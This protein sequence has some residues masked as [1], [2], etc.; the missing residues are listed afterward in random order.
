[1]SLAW[2]VP[3]APRFRT[4]D[5]RQATLKDAVARRPDLVV[6][7]PIGESEAGR[8]LYGAVVG[9]GPLVV[10]LIAGCHADE[11][12]GPETLTALVEG[13]TR[14]PT[15]AALLARVRFVVVP[16]VNPD[17]E[18]AN[19]R[20]IERWPDPAAYLRDNV[21]ESPGRDV[22]FGFPDLRAENRAVAAFLARYAPFVLHMSL[23]GMGVSEGALLLIERTW[24]G[25]RTEGLRRSFAEAVAAAGLAPHDHDRAGEKGFFRLGPGFQTTPEGAAMRRHFEAL[26]EAGTAAGF[27]DTSM[28]YVRSLGGDPLCLVTELPL[29]RLPRRPEPFCGV[30][31][32]YLAFQAA[33]PGLRDALRAGRDVLRPWGLSPLPLGAAMGL[34]LA[35]LEA[36]LAAMGA[37]RDE[38]V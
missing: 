9:H 27:H 7:E 2:I 17:G 12:V 23:H 20:W 33:R 36:G 19:R 24:A 3:P 4:A 32:A 21:R 18:V 16:H 14:D 8:P 6:V 13:L 35:A 22:E 10:S 28:E 30:P 25:V 5:E 37:G 34:Q 38:E 31:S 1:M 26:G 29:F 11:P 15:H